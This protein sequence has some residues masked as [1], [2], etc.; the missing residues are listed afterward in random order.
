[1]VLVLCRSYFVVSLCRQMAAAPVSMPTIA[2]GISRLV[3]AMPLVHL[4]TFPLY[5]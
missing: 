4:R 3:P 2:P 5:L 1:M